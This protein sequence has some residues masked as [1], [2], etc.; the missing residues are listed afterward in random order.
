MSF[1]GVGRKLGL[2]LINHIEACQ[3]NLV[4]QIFFFTGS[5]LYILNYLLGRKSLVC[6]KTKEKTLKITMFKESLQHKIERENS[7]EVEVM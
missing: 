6:L 3:T 2:S 1:I 4:T 7:E 5:S